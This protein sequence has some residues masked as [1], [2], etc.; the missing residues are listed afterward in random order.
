MIPIATLVSNWNIPKLKLTRAWIETVAS[1]RD[2][3]TYDLLTAYLVSGSNKLRTYNAIRF[4]PGIDV[5]EAVTMAWDKVSRHD[6]YDKEQTAPIAVQYGYFDA[7]ETLVG[8]L[9][10]SQPCFR[11]RVRETILWYTEARGRNDDLKKWFE[12][13]RHR[14][15]FDEKDKIFRVRKDE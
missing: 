14:L 13:N 5:P 1:F 4:L 6:T 7:L 9:D 12:Q 2:P 10:T 11:S 3:E 8:S 15:F